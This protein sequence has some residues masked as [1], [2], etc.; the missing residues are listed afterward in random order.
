MSSRW[1]TTQPA[2]LRLSK[3]N[4]SS[5]PTTV[6]YSRPFCPTDSKCNSPNIR[7]NVTSA[8]RT[9]P[10]KT[11]WWATHRVRERPRMND[12]TSRLPTTRPGSAAALRPRRPRRRNASHPRR[13][14]RA[15]GGRRN[16]IR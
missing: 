7:G 14:S 3:L 12:W 10:E 6:R 9:H 16:Q 4:V 11:S 8:A 5:S 2:T 15:V 13:F 1:K